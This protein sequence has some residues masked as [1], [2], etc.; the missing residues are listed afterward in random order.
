MKAKR[1]EVTSDRT[2][3]IVALLFLLIL[4]AAILYPLVYVVSASFSDP[5]LVSTGKIYLLPKGVNL[6][7]YMA[8]FQYPKVLRG[9]ANTIFYTVVGTFI[10]GEERLR[11][12]S[13]CEAQ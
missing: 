13:V 4:T 11:G 8:V 12:L 3:Y 9:Y 6:R 2:F 10:N 1:R 7:G 5:N